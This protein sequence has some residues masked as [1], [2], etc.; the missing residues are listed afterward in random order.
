MATTHANLLHV[1]I[2][3]HRIDER[4]VALVL[5]TVRR[6][7]HRPTILTSSKESVFRLAPPG[8]ALPSHLAR[9][10]RSVVA[11]AKRIRSRRSTAQS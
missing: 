4:N 10:L 1:G 11:V 5:R 9:T 6:K 2:K 3:L 8:M 7:E